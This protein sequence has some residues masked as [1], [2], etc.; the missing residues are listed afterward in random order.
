MYPTAIVSP[1][2]QVVIPKKVRQV[3]QNLKPGKELY[4]IPE[5][6]N[7]IR[8]MVKD[9]NWVRTARGIAKGVYGPDSTKYL[10]QLRQQWLKYR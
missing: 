1:K 4:V 8:L 2:Y 10:R 5:S 6:K 7:S 3:I 9:E